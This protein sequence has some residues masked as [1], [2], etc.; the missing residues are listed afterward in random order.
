MSH[1]EAQVMALVMRGHAAKEGITRQMEDA[2]EDLKSL[3]L[4]YKNE[5]G[6]KGEA[7]FIC[8]FSIFAADI[9]EEASK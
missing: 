4:R 8:A 9:S 7:A 2:L 5:M 1:S 3:R 6:D